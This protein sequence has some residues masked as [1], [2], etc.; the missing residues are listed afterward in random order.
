MKREYRVKIKKK[1][2]GDIAFCGLCFARNYI[3]KKEEVK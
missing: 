3:S 1:V 2:E